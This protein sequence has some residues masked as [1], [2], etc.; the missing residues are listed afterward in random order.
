MQKWQYAYLYE[1][2]LFDSAS[3]SSIHYIQAGASG[4]KVLGRV[5]PLAALDSLGADGWIISPKEYMNIGSTPHDDWWRS[6]YATIAK[7]MPQM[8]AIF[9]EGQYFMRRPSTEA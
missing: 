6:V 1:V 4:T 2:K 3:T 9:I 7:M 5:N 8:S